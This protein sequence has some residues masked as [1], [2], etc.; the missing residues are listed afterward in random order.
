MQDKEYKEMVIREWEHFNCDNEE[1]IM[2]QFNKYLKNIKRLIMDWIKE[3]Q[4][5]SHMDLHVV[6]NHIS[7]ICEQN[8]N[9]IFNGYEQLNLKRLEDSRRELLNW[10]I[11]Q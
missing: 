5:N 4:K 2:F 7:E 8:T 1:T 9:G 6:E 11:S 10:E 3:K